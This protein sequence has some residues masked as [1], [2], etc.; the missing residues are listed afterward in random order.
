MHCKVRR[1][2]INIRYL[3]LLSQLVL[4]LIA[5]KINKHLRLKDII[6]TIWF[7]VSLLHI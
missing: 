5:V 6:E 4:H 2:F 3:G 7:G 1:R